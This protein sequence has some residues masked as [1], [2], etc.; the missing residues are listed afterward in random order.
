MFIITAVLFPV[1]YVILCKL[2]GPMDG[3]K[4]MTTSYRMHL[5]S[6]ACPMPWM[7]WEDDHLWDNSDG[8]RENEWWM[9]VMTTYQCHDDC[10]TVTGLVR[11]YIC[12]TLFPNL[13]GC[14]R[15]NVILY[16][17]KYSNPTAI[18]CTQRHAPKEYAVLTFEFGNKIN[19][20]CCVWRYP[21]H[22]ISSCKV[23]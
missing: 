5:V 3:M 10:C 4:C 15:V 12:Y 6:V 8:D 18:W 23:H 7:E 1:Q 16:S 2:S 19:P 9:H 13:R 21:H 17:R 22:C 14:L 11:N 20:L